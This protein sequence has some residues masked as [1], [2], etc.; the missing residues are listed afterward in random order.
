MVI[1]TTTRD[2]DAKGRRTDVWL[3]VLSILIPLLIYGATLNGRVAS[4]YTSGILGTQFAFWRD[5]SFSLGPPG[6]LI[7]DTVD[8]RRV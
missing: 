3:G 7:T 4:D 5:R 6:S 2:R 8:K 1:A